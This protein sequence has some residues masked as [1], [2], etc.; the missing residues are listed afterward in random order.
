MERHAMIL[1]VT[2]LVPLIGSAGLLVH[3]AAWVSQWCYFIFD[4]HHADR[5]VQICGKFPW[6]M[7]LRIFDR[8]S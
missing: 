5:W 4:A 6:Q 2:G 1:F 3:G 7:A 8:F